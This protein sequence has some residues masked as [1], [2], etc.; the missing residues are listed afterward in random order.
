MHSSANLRPN[1]QPSEFRRLQKKITATF[2][3]LSAKLLPVNFCSS[4]ILRLN[5]RPLKR[6]LLHAP[7]PD[8]H[9]TLSDCNL[10]QPSTPSPE[11]TSQC[12]KFRKNAAL[13]PNH[14]DPI[15]GTR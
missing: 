12:S 14:R 2:D 4:P 6:P 7:R 8:C 1:S 9:Q 3:Q 5:H 13:L 15:N 11:L 10:L